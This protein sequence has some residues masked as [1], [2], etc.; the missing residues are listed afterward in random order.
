MSYGQNKK[1]TSI[2]Y[3]YEWVFG[4]FKFIGFLVFL[5]ILY[6]SNAHSAEKHLREIRVLKQEVKELQWEYLLLKKDIV[7][8]S[9]MSQLQERMSKE[10]VF[11]EGDFPTKINED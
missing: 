2:A 11:L 9:S 1:T 5:G 3:G 10:E 4:N 8:G 7:K 6:I